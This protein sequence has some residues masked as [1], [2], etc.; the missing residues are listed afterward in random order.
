ASKNGW[1]HTRR[2]SPY[3][4]VRL[5]RDVLEILNK[6]NFLI[7][8][9][10]GFIA[11]G[12]QMSRAGRLTLGQLRASMRSKPVMGKKI[13]RRVKTTPAAELKSLT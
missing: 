10:H 1:I 8:K 3:G 12:S 4:S 13:R 9:D 2:S 6:H 11:M 7:L 5:V